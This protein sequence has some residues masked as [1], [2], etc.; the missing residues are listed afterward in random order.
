LED[1]YKS[2]Q[3]ERRKKAR[4]EPE[5]FLDR[6][7]TP[8]LTFK[9]RPRLEN[10]NPNPNRGYVTTVDLRDITS[11]SGDNPKSSAMDVDSLDT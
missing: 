11:Q 10:L 2:V 9:P 8:N 4:T 3:E 7:P 6:K 5:S 1:D